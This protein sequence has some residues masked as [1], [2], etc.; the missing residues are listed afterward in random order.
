MGE[1]H[2]DTDTVT[3]AE[4]EVVTPPALLVEDLGA[5][6][7]LVLAVAVINR[8]ADVFLVEAELGLADD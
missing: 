5:T 1:L 8:P 4:L 3:A 6:A 2:P 7:G